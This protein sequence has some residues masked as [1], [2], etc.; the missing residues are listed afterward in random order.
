MRK[1]DPKT[2]EQLLDRMLSFDFDGDIRH[3]GVETAS[4]VRTGPNTILLSFPVSG[5]TFELSVHRP[6]EFSQVAARKGESRSFASEPE[7]APTRRLQRVE[8]EPAAEAPKARKRRKDAGQPRRQQGGEQ[9]T[10][11]H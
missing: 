4:I 8:P 7:D 3:L 6:R 5:I 11:S 1:N 9:R 10:G 2:K